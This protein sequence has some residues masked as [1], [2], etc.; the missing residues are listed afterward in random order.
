MH[1]ILRQNTSHTQ[2]LEE[3]EE[4]DQQQVFGLVKLLSWELWSTHAAWELWGYSTSIASQKKK[5]K[6]KS[7]LFC[8]CFLRLFPG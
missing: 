7:L 2:L 6:T 8:S 3:F 1:Q 5:K 4:F